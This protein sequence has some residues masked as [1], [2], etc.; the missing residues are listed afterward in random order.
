MSEELEQQIQS[1]RREI[2]SAP[3][4]PLQQYQPSHSGMA[5]RCGWCGRFSDDLE[6][7]EVAHGQERYKGG[8]CR[9]HIGAE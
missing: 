4:V 1:E 7:V 8:C 3:K 2:E 5:G 6:L 9:P